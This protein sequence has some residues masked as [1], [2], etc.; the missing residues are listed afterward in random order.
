MCTNK[1]EAG[2]KARASGYDCFVLELDSKV[3]NVLILNLSHANSFTLKRAGS[4]TLRLLCR[5]LCGRK[6]Q[7]CLHNDRCPASW[8]PTLISMSDQPLSTIRTRSKKNVGGIVKLFRDLIKQPKSVND[9][10]AQSNSTRISASSAFGAHDPGPENDAGRASSKY[11]GSIFV[12][13]DD[14]TPL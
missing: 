13:N 10:A 12:I 11:I 7:I 5:W 8:S 1:P 6:R 4:R 2:L 3:S 14:L 9:S